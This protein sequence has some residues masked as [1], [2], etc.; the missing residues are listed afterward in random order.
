MELEAREN[1]SGEIKIL[2]T[3]GFMNMFGISKTKTYEIFNQ[4]EFP[5]F[6]FDRKLFVTETD[7]LK[8]IERQKVKRTNR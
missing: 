1:K 5:S 3:K 8:W 7:L 6:K 4:T 2:S